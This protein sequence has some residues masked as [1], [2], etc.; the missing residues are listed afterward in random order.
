M[1]TA[2]FHV[3]NL[4]GGTKDAHNHSFLVAYPVTA[5]FLRNGLMNRQNT[6]SRRI[7]PRYRRLLISQ[8]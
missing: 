8:V 1:L 3:A 5:C 2:C 6:R 7:F 4:S